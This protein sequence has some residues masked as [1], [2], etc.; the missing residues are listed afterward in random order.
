MNSAANGSRY[1]LLQPAGAISVIGRGSAVCVAAR[2]GA[3]K[4]ASRRGEAVQWQRL[5]A[6]GGGAGRGLSLWHLILVGF[7]LETFPRNFHV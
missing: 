4:A 3:G 2:E 1:Q 5:L 7:H 6:G